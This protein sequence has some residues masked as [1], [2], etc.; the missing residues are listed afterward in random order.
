MPLSGAERAKMYRDRL[1]ADS[2]SHKEYLE[3]EK[4]RYKK[5]KEKGE[6]KSID[7]MNTREKR[8]QRRE[9]RVKKRDQRKRKKNLTEVLNDTPPPTPGPW[10]IVLQPEQRSK[11]GRKIVQ[12]NRSKVYRELGKVKEQL[13]KQKRISEKYKKRLQRL[14]KK[15]TDSPR[16]K[17][18]HLLKHQKVTEEVRKALLF[19][20]AFIEGIKQKYKK[21]RSERQKQ[22]M[23]KAVTS[24]ILKKYRLV[25]VASESLSMSQR[26][27]NENIRASNK[28]QYSR[29]VRKNSIVQNMKAS[30]EGFLCRDDNSRIKTGKKSTITKAGVKKQRRLLCDTLQN[31]HSKYL[32][33]NLDHKISY[34][35]FCMLRPFYV[36][37]PSQRDRESCLCKKHENLIFKAERLFQNG[38]IKSKDIVEL[39]RQLTCNADSKACMYRECKECRDK[40]IETKEFDE[41]KMTEWFE[42][43]TKRVEREKTEKGE[44]KIFT[45]AIT[46]KETETGPAK[47]LLDEFEMDLKKAC[48]HLYNIS[49]QY[50]AIRSLK[51]SLT[52]HDVL[53]HIDFSENYT[54]QYSKAISST[55]FGASQ[56]QISLHTGVLYTKGKTESF[57][58]ISD[59]L[60]HGPGAIWAHLDPVLN[61]SRERNSDLQNV[62]FLSDGPTTQYRCKDNFYL[63]SVKVFEKGFKNGNWN[64]LEAGHGKG[65]P[66]GIG[67]VI[68]REA[69]RLVGHGKDITNAKELF[70]LLQENKLAVLLFMVE[71]EGVRKTEDQILSKLSTI[72]GTMK[73]HQV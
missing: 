62:Y 56:R 65:A 60:K 12:K 9:W 68:K 43:R 47:Q 66:D 48:T 59:S 69:D 49:H 63:F 24:S 38:V 61:Y 46:S 14:K 50:R 19:H 29:K 71:E 3:K 53:L 45:V 16:S 21:L 35:M 15:S 5:R 67:A 28:L 73:I 54:C 13:A 33:E 51:E 22:I 6:I 40:K 10:P 25:K 1:K 42:W 70:D 39:A 4:A 2:N 26:R 20:N 64:F 57:C 52:D 18:K 27:L 32:S 8:K 72:P 36:L 31:L 30:V 17:T 34:T 55:H 58:T 41:S 7:D 23:S 11:R 37:R 44:T